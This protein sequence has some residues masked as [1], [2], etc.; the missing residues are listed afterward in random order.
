[1]LN[2]LNAGTTTLGDITARDVDGRGEEHP[3]TVCFCP[4]GGA[5]DDGHECQQRQAIVDGEE[6]LQMDLPRSL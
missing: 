4:E 2:S 1:M 3:A 6:D 5:V